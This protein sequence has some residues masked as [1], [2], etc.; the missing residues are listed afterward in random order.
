MPKVI[1]YVRVSTDKQDLNNQRFEIERF[2]KQR[3]YAVDEWDQEIVSGTIKVKDRS[4]S[5]V[6]D[7][8]VRD[9]TLVVSEVSRISRRLSTILITIEDCVER[10]IKVV[11]V[12]ESIVF[13]G[14]LN[15]QIISWA[16][17]MAAQIERS[18]ISARTKEAL[19]RKRA[20]GVQLGRPVGSTK[21]EHYKLHG[22][23]D[24]I[25]RMLDKRVSVSAIARLLDVNRKTLTDYINR[26]ELRRRLLL[27]RLEETG[28]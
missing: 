8:L 9:D 6:L 23:D 11:S 13:D 19:A 26:Q 27:K 5:R 24:R 22:K 2:C 7:R 25:I 16:F 1:A 4:I 21:P 12:K 18:L 14:G 15:S 17:G 28:V 3:A 20:E 10:G